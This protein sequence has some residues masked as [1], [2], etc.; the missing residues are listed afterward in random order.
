L[1]IDNADCARI[2]RETN[3][4]PTPYLTEILRCEVSS[5]EA[6][7]QSVRNS[8]RFRVGGM[9]LQDLIPP[10][11]RSPRAIV[12]LGRLVLARVRRVGGLPAVRSRRTESAL[13]DAD[14]IVLGR[15]LDSLDGIGA[16]QWATGDAEQVALR[17]DE[18]SAP[19]VL[20][21]RVAAPEVLRRLDRIRMKG[22]KT[23]WWPDDE[24]GADAA[25]VSFA[26]AHCEEA[27]EG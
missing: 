26:R 12:A 17:L 15:R 19:A 9:V 21:L 7:I 22:W 5:L 6:E 13:P 1:P 16:C 11:R 2:S 4:D 18:E 23:V 20:V 3:F 8:L 24:L 25:L 10:S 27:V 14:V